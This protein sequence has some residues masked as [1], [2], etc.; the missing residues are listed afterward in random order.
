MAVLHQKGYTLIEILVVITT[1]GVLTSI[2]LAALTPSR[3]RARDARRITDV[4]QLQGAINNFFS[5]CYT[6]PANLDVLRVG[7]SSCPVYV[8]VLTELPTDP[9]SGLPYDYYVENS[10]IKR[11][12]VCA[13]TEN[14]VDQSSGKL[15]LVGFDVINSSDP[16]HGEVS[17]VFDL[18]GGVY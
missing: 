17:N 13:E 8:R 2:I 1:I 7:T 5:V 16:C 14:D 9:S 11:Y 10:P 4:K 12:H 3:I 18:A 6:Y 15:G